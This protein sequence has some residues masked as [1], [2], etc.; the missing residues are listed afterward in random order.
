MNRYKKAVEQYGDKAIAMLDDE[1]IRQKETELILSFFHSLKPYP[2]VVADVGCGDG[3][4]LEKLSEKYPSYPFTFFGFDITKELLDIAKKRTIKNCVFIERD[5]TSFGTDNNFFDII[6]TQ[7]C[8]INILSWDEQKQ[9]LEEI[10]RVLKLHGQYL[11]IE[12]FTD[13]LENN[14]KARMECGLAALEKPS[15]NNY[16]D[17]DRLFK[18]TKDKFTI[19][20]DYSNYFS[21]HYFISRV[22]HAL[23]TKGE[24]EKNTEFVK[25]FSYLPPIGNY[26]PL[27]AYIFTKVN[28]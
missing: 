16:F 5:A 11:M 24:Q 15:Y 4:T 19:Q 6:Y 10:H 18:W 12:G 20:S 1:V 28:K 8:L 21:S 3:Y 13:G 25:F 14:N 9:A 2:R 26:A 22:L 7:R 17:K 27:Q 23:V